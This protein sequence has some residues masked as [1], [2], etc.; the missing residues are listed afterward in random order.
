ESEDVDEESIAGRKFLGLPTKLQMKFKNTQL[1]IVF[2]NKNYTDED[3]EEMFL[4]LQ[5]GTP[6]NAAEKRR[7]FPGNMKNIVIELSKHNVFKICSFS[8][9]RFAYEDAVAKIL[10]MILNGSVTDI[11]PISIKKTYSSN[12]NINNNN[13]S[14]KIT[15]QVFNLLYTAFKNEPPQFKKFSI[16]S[17]AFITSNL[18]E[19]YNIRKYKKS[20]SQ[21]YNDFESI[22]LQNEELSEGEQDGELAAYTDAARSD[23]VANMQY[24]HDLLM[25][26]IIEAIPE[27][28]LKDSKRDFTQEQRIA[29]YHR[30]KGVCKKCHKKC[31]ENDFEAHHI[32]PHKDGGITK[33]SN[34]QLL[35]KECH[36]EIHK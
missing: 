5:N 13:P 4:R 10:H 36:V 6:L 14:V 8:D 17:I 20:F 32:L 18:L 21:A 15:K 26:K 35:C 31:S 3:I 28:E 23:S 9:K 7:V 27:L 1:D 29:I 33:I 34:G 11:R 2:L 16:I 25:R 30:D 24:R 12:V 19:K 22:R